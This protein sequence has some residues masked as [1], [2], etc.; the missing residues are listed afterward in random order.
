MGAAA[1]FGCRRLK[2]GE[3]SGAEECV[4][5]KY[6]STQVPSTCYT[7][8]RR[9]VVPVAA[10]PAARPHVR[11]RGN[12]PCHLPFAGA[13][14]TRLTGSGIYTA[15][16]RRTP[17]C[18]PV[19]SHVLPA[20]RVTR[21]DSSPSAA[22]LLASLLCS[23]SPWGP[24]N[25]HLHPRHPD[26][27]VESNAQYAPKTIGNYTLPT[28]SLYNPHRSPRP[29]TDPTCLAR[30][31]ARNHFAS[32]RAY[33]SPQISSAIC[34][35]SDSFFFSSSSLSGYPLSCVLNPHCGLTAICLSASSL[36]WPVPSATNSAA[37]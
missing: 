9:R 17:S 37:L 28:P 6:P 27:E 29:I 8:K 14:T 24:H 22:S 3:K 25:K 26:V 5:T 34:L 20:V 23:T 30:L 31:V 33:G 18:N 2:C 32:P 4:C 12:P 10:S 7:A 13:P 15:L 19:S 16:V 11:R 1:G 21:L 36:V 35:T